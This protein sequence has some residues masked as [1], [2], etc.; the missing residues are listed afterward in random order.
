[1][2]LDKYP[3]NDEQIIQWNNYIN[4]KK[5]YP[6]ELLI[7]KKNKNYEHLQ[8]IF[9]TLILDEISPENFIKVY[10][11]AKTKNDIVFFIRTMTDLFL[12]HK[13]R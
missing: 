5:I 4:S 13:V 12:S 9:K 6:I 3:K 8:K 1:M 10:I 11:K 2:P 7:N